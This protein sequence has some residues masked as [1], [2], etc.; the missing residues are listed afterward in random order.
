MQVD[1]YQLLA[2]NLALTVFAVIAIGYLLARIKIADIELGATTGVL[3]AGLVLGHFG[4]HI[5]ELVGTFG[6][7]LFIFTIGLQAGPSFFT[8]VAKD[9][10]KYFAMAVA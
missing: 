9:G 4:L 7:V 5:H 3:L 1:L 8:V 6:F 10:A 2:D